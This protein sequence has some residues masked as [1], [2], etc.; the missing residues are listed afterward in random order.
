MTTLS[1]LHGRVL[2]YLMVEAIIEI[3]PRTTLTL[4]A[5]NA[6]VRDMNKL[7][8]IDSVLLQELRWAT[9]AFL[10]K[11]LNPQ[12]QLSRQ[13]S[14]KIDRLPDQN[15]TDVTDICLILP[16]ELVNLSIKHNNAALRHQRP[17]TTPVHCGYSRQDIEM[18]QF[19]Q[20]YRAITQSFMLQVRQEKLFANLPPTLKEQELYT[21]ICNLVS[22]FINN[23]SDGCVLS[24]FEISLAAKTT[25][26]LL[27]IHVQ[28]N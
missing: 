26:K 18:Q 28:R 3:Q 5:R 24:L 7:T 21:P 8:D 1:N 11:W 6:Q 15:Q 12:F 17:G 19:Q 10:T 4:R 27:L 9:N 25:T 20:Q 22:Q 23:H 14:I 16:R 13:A 2:E